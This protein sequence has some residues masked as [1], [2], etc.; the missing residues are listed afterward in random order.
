MDISG[1]EEETPAVEHQINKWMQQTVV[2]KYLMSS[3]I[4]HVVITEYCSYDCGFHV[5]LYIKGFHD[6]VW[7]DWILLPFFHYALINDSSL[8]YN[9]YLYYLYLYYL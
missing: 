9:F 3:F 5:L 7:G 6:S 4:P 2:W 1:Y 8:L